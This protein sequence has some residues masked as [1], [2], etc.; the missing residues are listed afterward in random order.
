MNNPNIYILMNNIKDLSPCERQVV[1]YVLDNKED[2]TSDT[3]VEMGA[4]SYTSASTVT[5]VIKKLGY[6]RFND[7]K[8]ALVQ[9]YRNYLESTMLF[10]KKETIHGDD[11]IQDIIDK[12]TTNSI[13]ALKSVSQLNSAETFQTIV[14]YMKNASVMHFFGSGV[15]N[16]ICKDAM[17]KGLRSGCNVTAHTYFSEMM[18][19]AKLSS[20]NHLAFIISY[21]GQTSEML[22]IANMLKENNVPTVSI[23]SD[24]NNALIN[25]CNYNLFV[26]NSES[27]Y[28]VGGMESRMSMQNILDIL[29]SI[30]FSQHKLARDNI[31]RTFVD[32]TF[33]KES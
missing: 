9:D 16:L 18:M 31:E 12:T 21:T 11:S 14:S 25:L 27:V 1:N 33:K 30:Y 10:Q 20:R 26:D 2:V 17:M 19:Q 23:T 7:F 6:E 8:F 5:R 3:I 15:S 28:R 29:F 22:K 32:E 13:M 4:K 24:S